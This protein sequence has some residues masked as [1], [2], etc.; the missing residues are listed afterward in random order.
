MAH[1]IITVNENEGQTLAVVGDI[2]RI[3][4]SGKQTGGAYAVIDML[5]PPGGGPGPHA[6]ADIQESFYVIEGEIQFK[7]E[8]GIYK[9]EKGS[10]VNIPKGGEVHCFR[11]ISNTT[12]HMLCTVIPAGLDEFF[13]A[14]G[15]PVAPGSF[16]P[17]PV[18]TEEALSKLKSVA[19]KYGQKLYPPDYLG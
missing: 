2:Y 17:P 5:V 7:T 4:I 13:E 3:I 18:L 1:N 14:I 15:T 19:E 12:A 16:L 10:F 8:G 11:N 9:A 6:H